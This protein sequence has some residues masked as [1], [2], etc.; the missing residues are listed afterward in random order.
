MVMATIVPA[1]LADRTPSS[2]LRDVTHGCVECGTT[3]VRTIRSL[4]DAA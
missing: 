4:A 1:L 3:L 2:D